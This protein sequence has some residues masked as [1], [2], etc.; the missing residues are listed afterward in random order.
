MSNERAQEDAEPV[1]VMDGVTRRF[2]PI[3]A[4]AGVSWTVRAG[5][6]WWVIGPNGGGKTT[7]LG[8][9]AGLLQP[10]AGTVWRR[11]P[12]ACVP[13]RETI[14]WRYPACV[15]DVVAMGGWGG[16]W[17]RLRP[18][19]PDAVDRALT[20]FGLEE[21]ASRPVTALS[22]G[23]QQRVLLA[24]ALASPAGLFLLDEPARGLDPEQEES[25]S[26]WLARLA[27][28]G[29]A[30]VVVSHDLGRVARSPGR[31]LAI[32]GRVVDRGPASRVLAPEVICRLFGSGPA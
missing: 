22:G 12:V 25:L 15:R 27:A 23:Q 19:A 31:F 17:W 28:G 29:T 30:V 20:A 3:Q 10:D 11:V 18:A 8:L 1:L 13:Q 6:L 32:A 14:N 16:P 24:R 9:A 5:D 4:L 2:G 21:L 7:L 26:G